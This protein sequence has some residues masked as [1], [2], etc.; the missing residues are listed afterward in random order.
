LR[1]A[2][3]EGWRVLDREIAPL[4]SQPFRDLL[5]EDATPWLADRFRSFFEERARAQGRPVFVHKFT[6][7]PRSGFVQAS[8]PGARFINVVRDGRAVVNSW[9]QMQWWLGYRGP[10]AWHYGPLPPAYAAEWEASGRSFVTLA[11]LAWKILMD[12][13][14]AA[15]ARIPADHWLDLHYEDFLSDPRSHL[16]RMLRFVGLEWNAAFE[17]GLARTSFRTDRQRAYRDEI[18]G[19]QLTLLERSLGD[20]LARWGYEVKDRADAS[21]ASAPSPP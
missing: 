14:E 10:A 11:G 21:P 9:L 17:R 6:G 3:S 20:H 19:A 12:A 15:R 7:W 18:D 8:L 2:P 13:F 5:A 1:F 16:E 4:L